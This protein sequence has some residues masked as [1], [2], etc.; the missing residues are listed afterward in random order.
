MLA[1]AG[2]GYRDAPEAGSQGRKEKSMRKLLAATCVGFALVAA[3]FA[4]VAGATK[5]DHGSHG[6]NVKENCST[7]SE[8]SPFFTFGQGHPATVYHYCNPH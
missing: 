8:D 1:G 6:T 2:F 3:S 4:P 5:E 7:N